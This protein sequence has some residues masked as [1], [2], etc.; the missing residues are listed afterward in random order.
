VHRLHR[1]GRQEPHLLPSGRG[2]PLAG[3]PRRETP[4]AGVLRAGRPVVLQVDGA[5]AG[6]GQQA[7]EGRTDAARPAHQ[8][9]AAAASPQHGARGWSVDQRE[10]GQIGSQPVALAPVQCGQRRVGQ[11][12]SAGVDEQ[13]GPLEQVQ[14]A[15]GGTR[16]AVQSVSLG[17]HLLPRAGAVE[18]R[19]HVSHIAVDTEEDDAPPRRVADLQGAGVTPEPSG[20][21]QEH[22]AHGKPLPRVTRGPGPEPSP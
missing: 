14:Q 19:E 11:V 17:Q 6:G 22:R 3:I 5:H 16:W 1:R 9:A 8:H 20:S 13:P 7:G 18:Q 2:P 10:A 21:G 12:E 15:P 4:D